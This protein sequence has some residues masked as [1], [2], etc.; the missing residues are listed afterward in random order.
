[1]CVCG[2][3]CVP[4]CVCGHV[5]TC[6][7]VCVWVLRVGLGPTW[8]PFMGLEQ[9]QTGLVPGTLMGRGPPAEG[10]GVG[11]YT[12]DTPAPSGLDA[13][14]SLEESDGY[15]AHPRLGWASSTPAPARSHLSVLLPA[16]P[17]DTLARLACV[18]SVHTPMTL[19]L[20]RQGLLPHPRL[21][22][23]PG[24]HRPQ[25]RVTVFPPPDGLHCCG[26]FL[27]RPPPHDPSLP[28]PPSTHLALPTGWVV[29]I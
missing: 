1:M 29:G 27:E 17:E 15:P 21:L 28:L 10:G 12:T 26:A 5:C 22:L 3:T 23:N 7:C 24:V 20:L 25:D 11:V 9:L 8:L 14:Q 6:A 16:S 13:L 19:D 2:G 4:V 18:S